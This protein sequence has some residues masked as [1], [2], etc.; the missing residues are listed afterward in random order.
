[1]TS[2]DQPLIGQW[3][4]DPA[5]EQSFRVVA[6]DEENDSIEIQYA[7]GDISGLDYNSWLEGEF[8]SI[9]APEDWSAPFDNV[10]NDDLG[11]S[12]PDVHGPDPH[13]ITLIDILNDDKNLA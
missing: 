1:M 2:S 10:E 4:R 11:Y 9:E 13:N 7:D 5:T 8:D 12:D 6:Q 3:Y